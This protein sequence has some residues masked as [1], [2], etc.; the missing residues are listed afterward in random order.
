MAVTMLAMTPP[1]N[2]AA[3]GADDAAPPAIETKT[4]NRPTVRSA[5]TIATKRWRPAEIEMI[6][7]GPIAKIPRIAAEVAAEPNGIAVPIETNPAAIG[8]V[9]SDPAAID[10]AASGPPTR[11]DHRVTGRPPVGL[12]P[13]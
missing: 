8:P 6:L 12:V 11:I 13:V 10:H 3:A 2:V 4:G 7:S 5:V 9:A 1:G